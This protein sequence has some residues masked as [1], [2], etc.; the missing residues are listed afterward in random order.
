MTARA[1]YA[2]IAARLRE[3]RLTAGSA[4]YTD[5]VQ[6]VADVRDRRGVPAVQQRPARAT[7][8]DCFNP[9]RRRF[10]VELVVDIAAALGLED[11]A[12]DEFVQLCWSV[13][14]GL[15]SA[16]IVHVRTTVPQP[17]H[18][19]VG[20]TD[21]LSALAG[22]RPDRVVV[23]EGMAGTGKTTLVCEAARRRVADGDADI[24]VIAELRGFAPDQPPADPDAVVDAIVR[25][26]GGDPLRLRSG[27][28]RHEG[29]SNLLAEHRVL[30]VLDD[31][32]DAAQV[33]PLL[34]DSTVGVLVTSR[35]AIAGLLGVPSV[36]LDVMPD[37]D[38]S[39]LLQAASGAAVREW[40]A[41][42]LTELAG[43]V[44]RL[45]LALGVAASR[46]VARPDWTSADHARSLVGSHGEARL[47]DAVRAVLDESHASLDPDA[48]HLLRMVAS[49]PL[50]AFGLASIT[51]MCGGDA[52]AASAAVDQLADA[53]LV[54]R[55]T[56][57]RLTMH[58]LVRAHARDRSLDADRPTDRDQALRALIDHLVATSRAAAEASET[59]PLD[60]LR[61]PI[62][63][64]PT[65][66]DTAQAL[67]WMDAEFENL[68][69]ASGDQCAVLRPSVAI[70]LAESLGWYVDRRARYQDA[71]ILHDR[72]VA[73]ARALGDSVGEG[74]AELGRGQCFTRLG[75]VTRA[76]TSIRRAEVHLAGDERCLARVKNA[77]A[78]WAFQA[79]EWETSIT[80]LLEATDLQQ[81]V[82]S[83]SDL[84]R[85]HGNL[86]V[87]YSRVGQLDR[88]VGH[89]ER[90]AALAM[91]AGDVDTAA[92]TWMNSS[93]TQLLRGDP[94]A[95]LAAAERAVALS[96]AHGVNAVLPLARNN[97]GGALVELGRIDE[98]IA[99]V[100]RAGDEA[101]A[102]GDRLGELETL[103][104]LGEAY[105][106]AGRIA[107]AEN[108]LA[109]AH[110]TAAELGDA[111]QRGRALHAAGRVSLERGDL[112]EA[113]SRLTVALELLG[114]DLPVSQRIRD[115]L[116]GLPA[117][118]S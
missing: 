6:R 12:L 105:L 54:A 56:P 71:L 117:G 18:R 92:F 74:L 7:V 61:Y 72:A 38:A 50:E 77:L 51:A 4:S 86:A 57:D 114:D 68:L 80:A 94:Q 49:A 1:T 115:V 87:V 44:G 75:D 53:Y 64:E 46:I 84:A 22:D 19:F 5:I 116:A 102:I 40:T 15:D 99:Q 73:A 113:R 14:H 59:R 36:P 35:N 88:A 48:S 21:E 42:Q 112:D 60:P 32:A 69:A 111:F 107:D 34:P 8:Y 82:G 25:S 52:A 20:R 104:N 90:A 97:L 37:D 27:G 17:P 11:A 109:V 96:E 58:A 110:D 23:V 31:A 24:V 13:Q 33:E 63:A 91:D 103:I 76:I 55:P 95:A 47:D 108:Q 28:E 41:A 45:P 16:R 66:L 85:C 10:D 39:A 70:E 26:I 81:R 106:S 83:P 98:G 30:L 93:G 2:N 43:I 118:I 62:P 79:G 78:V 29:Y 89:Q 65:P 101:R 100:R 9:D 67:A 3:L